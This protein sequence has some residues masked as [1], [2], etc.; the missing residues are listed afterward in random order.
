MN[1]K[2]I[3]DVLSI[4]NLIYESDLDQ[5]KDPVFVGRLKAAAFTKALPLK[6]AIEKLNVEVRDESHCS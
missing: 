4:L 6:Y 5:F 3:S 2:N 1:A